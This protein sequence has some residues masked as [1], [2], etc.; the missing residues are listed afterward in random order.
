MQGSGCGDC[1]VGLNVEGSRFRCMVLRCG[2][3]ARRSAGEPASSL[4]YLTESVDKVVLKKSIT[5]QI[6]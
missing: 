4:A 3:G 2:V 5:A 6:R 1:G